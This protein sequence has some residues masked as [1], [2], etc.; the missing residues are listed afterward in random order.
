MNVTERAE[1]LEELLVEHEWPP[2]DNAA[3]EPPT[4]ADEDLDFIE[5]IARRGWCTRF[6]LEGSF[7]VEGQ[8]AETIAEVLD[9]VGT[10]YVTVEDKWYPNEGWLV[11]VQRDS[12]DYHVF[13]SVD[14]VHASDWGEL[15]LLLEAARP[16]L[17]DEGFELFQ[18]PTSD[19]TVLLAGLPSEIYEEAVADGLI[20]VG[21]PL[22]MEA[23]QL[24]EKD[25]RQ[26]LD[27]HRRAET[28]GWSGDDIDWNDVEGSIR[29]LLDEG[30]HPDAS[31]KYGTTLLM[32][33]IVKNVPIELSREML[34][35]G[36]DPNAVTVKGDSIL[37]K[38]AKEGLVDAVRLLGEYGAK[39]SATSS[40]DSPLIAAI[41]TNRGLE[42]AK[43]LLDMGA[44]PDPIHAAAQFS[45]RLDYLK[46]F[47]EHGADP[48]ARGR[49]DRT[50]LFAIFDDSGE[51]VEMLVEFGADPNLTNARGQTALFE[52]ARSDNLE[53]AKAL[54]EAGI[55]T[56]VRD[57]YG[58]TALYVA[59]DK[60]ADDVAEFLKDLGA[61]Q[62]N[63][64]FHVS[65]A[66]ETR[67]LI[68]CGVDP[69]IT[70][71]EGFNPLHEAAMDDTN[72]GAARVLLDAGADL[73]MRA[74]V[75]EDRT[76]LELA[77][78]RGSHEIAAMIE[79]EMEER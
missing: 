35:A 5:P 60:G 57:V 33:G 3:I 74:E 54:V 40:E 22:H 28:V 13:K 44:D 1:Q 15:D 7:Q 71:T 78:W 24:S 9:L 79:A 39:P 48:N 21:E 30:V 17:R 31:G 51:T 76:P 38:A 27:E 61:L 4:A 52:A 65:E 41:G 63:N 59:Q 58:Q 6:D 45:S 72:K 18:A 42:L 69:N 37:Y 70:Q 64:I 73:N 19:Q 66:D 34:E 16:A 36:A 47:L 49:L 32:V 55:D 8:H 12:G 46:L 43:V 53:V 10:D 50:P 75:Y 56:D 20:D 2:D 62:G 29:R 23:V 11:G 26:F 68:R 67:Q 77:R 25:Y 14:R